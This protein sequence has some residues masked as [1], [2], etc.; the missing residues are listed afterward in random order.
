M[1]TRLNGNRS[2]NFNS[3]YINLNQIFDENTF[4]KFKKE[5]NLRKYIRVN[6]RYFE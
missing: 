6:L 3:N 2:F 4:L 5:S 1:V